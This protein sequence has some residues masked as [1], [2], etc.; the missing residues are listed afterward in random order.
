MHGW[1]G[2]AALHQRSECRP[3]N[4]HVGRAETRPENIFCRSRVESSR[5]SVRP[6]SW[7]T[8]ANRSEWVIVIIVAEYQWIATFR[9]PFAAHMSRHWLAINIPITS[10]DPEWRR[11]NTPFEIRPMFGLFRHCR[12]RLQSLTIACIQ[13]FGAF[14]RCNCGSLKHLSHSTS[15]EARLKWL[16]FSDQWQLTAR[17][18]PVMCNLG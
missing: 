7:K 15:N 17:S 6:N 11:Q 12:H 18:V 4:K 14:V 16:V 5:V 3:P 2:F 9:M 8:V 10:C 1:R 13:R